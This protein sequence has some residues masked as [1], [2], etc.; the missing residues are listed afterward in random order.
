MVQPAP[1]FSSRLRAGICI[2]SRSGAAGA[3][4]AQ[5]CRVASRPRNGG[6][7][8]CPAKFW[9]VGLCSFDELPPI[10][11]PLFARCPLKW[12]I[13][14]SWGS[15]CSPHC[16]WG[17]PSP[18]PTPLGAAG[19]LRPVCMDFCAGEVRGP[20]QPS[21]VRG[22]REAPARGAS[23]GVFRDFTSDTLLICVSHSL[24]ACLVALGRWVVSLAHLD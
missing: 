15:G 22:G 1:L 14:F 11:T 18:R 10:P 12:G 24:W 17:H 23:K 13:G 20:R 3:G 6:C 5:A 4:C 2:P 16:C 9:Q 8:T 7:V 19:C 21:R